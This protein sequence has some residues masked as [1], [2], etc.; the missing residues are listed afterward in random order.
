ML[1]LLDLYPCVIPWWAQVHM[2]LTVQA[3]SELSIRLYHEQLLA[4]ECDSASLSLFV[5]LL[6][7]YLTFQDRS[8]VFIDGKSNRLDPLA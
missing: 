1:S 2:A 8:Y 3:T 6:R 5:G 4:S 7:P